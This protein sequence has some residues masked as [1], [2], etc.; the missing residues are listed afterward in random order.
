MWAKCFKP[1]SAAVG[2]KRS[3]ATHA[4]SGGQP[5]R[6]RLFQR[7]SVSIKCIV[8]KVPFRSRRE[9]RADHGD[10]VPGKELAN[11][12][13]SHETACY[14]GTPVH[15][16]QLTP[17]QEEGILEEFQQSMLV[18]EG[19]PILRDEPVLVSNPLYTEA[20]KPEGDEQPGCRHAAV[21]AAQTTCRTVDAD[22]QVQLQVSQATAV[23]LYSTDQIVLQLEAT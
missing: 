1:A 7:R 21:L 22:H 11:R 2:P 5:V 20:E 18:L 16:Q 15:P 4:L 23:A 17:S 8:P 13:N 14:P 3:K 10:L 6:S 12:G 9:Q 19:P